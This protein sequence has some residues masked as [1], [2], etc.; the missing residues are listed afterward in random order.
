MKSKDFFRKF[1]DKYLWGNLLAMAVVVVA[2][3]LGLKYGLDRYTHHGEEIPVPDVRG[4]GFASAKALLEGDGLRVEVGD[5]GYNKRMPADCVL[6]QNPAGGAK[7]KS[8]HMIYVTVNS[9]STPT[10]TI[11][12]IVDNSSVREAEARLRAMGFRMLDPKPVAG[13]KD[14]VYGI[15]AGGRRV[16][17]GDRVP[18][19]VPLQLQVGSGM[20]DDDNMEIDYVESD[21]GGMESEIDEFEVVTG[22]PA[23]EA[24]D[25]AATPQQQ[26]ITE[27]TE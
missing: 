16:S 14:W 17:M 24:T 25:P 6:L 8:G 3:F 1:L 13:E 4:M 21:Y 12:D 27:T 18:I 15:T 20:Y 22:P 5:T 26:P 7:V 19:D 23:D 9:K 2:L 11:P 10:L